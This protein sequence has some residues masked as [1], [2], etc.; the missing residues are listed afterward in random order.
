MISHAQNS[1]QDLDDLKDRALTFAYNDPQ[2]LSGYMALWADPLLSKLDLAPKISGGHFL[3]ITM[4]LAQ[5]ADIALIDSTVLEAYLRE[6]PAAPLKI[7]SRLGPYPAPPLVLSERL[8]ASQREKLQELICNMHLDK[9]AKKA[10]HKAGIKRFDRVRG[11][12]Y[13]GLKELYERVV[14]ERSLT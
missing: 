10:L 1:Y 2:S 14:A 11:E 12:D 7:L 5:E 13:L 4:I 8:P 9:E 3:S 6:Y